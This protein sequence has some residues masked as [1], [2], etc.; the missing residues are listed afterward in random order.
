MALFP[1]P[2]I[3]WKDTLIG[4]MP[5]IGNKQQDGPLLGDEDVWWEVCREEYENSQITLNEPNHQE[6]KKN[7]K[8]IHIMTHKSSW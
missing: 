3:N 7:S 8:E 2:D 1:V 6:T 5:V 4:T